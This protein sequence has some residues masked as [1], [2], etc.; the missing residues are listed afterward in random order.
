MT[1][2]SNETPAI[3]F[4]E[5]GR[6]GFITLNRP[7]KLNALTHDMIKSL[8]PQYIKWGAPGRIYG[9]VLEAA[10][11]ST[12]C[13]GGDV[14]AIAEAAKADP[15]AAAEYFRDEYQHDWTLEC[16]SK[17]HV[18]L[19]DGMVMGGG[20][21]ISIYGTHRVAG[22][23]YGLAMP[24]VG[25]GFFPDVGASFVLARLPGEMG[26]YLGLTGRSIGRADACYLELVSHCVDA[27]DF[28]KV[29][30]AMIEGDPIDP[31]LDDLHRDPGVSKLAELQPV[32]DRL[33]EGSTV[34]EILTNLD[35][36]QGEHAAWA[37]ETAATIRRSAP[38]SLKITLRHIREARKFRNVKEALMVDFRIASRM[39][40]APDLQE[41]VRAMLI[42]KDRAPQWQPRTLAEVSDAMVDAYFAPLISENELEL[43]DHWTLVV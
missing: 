2:Q 30:H 25:I 22:E 8:G 14:L 7:E 39:V 31:V 16:F 34:E 10:P 42:D 37:Q 13:S 24:E 29:R 43:T 9:I 21:G 40:G 4:R 27:A 38:L 5:E 26:V 12:F 35:A 41:G 18:A 6:A 28:D 23:N 1:D 36:E 33:F 3:L 32:I 20:V 11:C 15:V 17:P 19:I